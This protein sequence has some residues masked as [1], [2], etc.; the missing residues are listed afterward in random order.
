MK[1]KVADAG[2]RLLVLVLLVLTATQ[3]VYAAEYSIELSTSG[4]VVLGGTVEFHATLLTDGKPVDDQYEVDWSDNMNP[5]NT[6]KN[7]QSKHP[8]FNWTTTYSNNNH[9]GSY[10]TTVIVRRY[11]YITY[12]EAARKSIAFNLT[13]LLNGQM[14]L[15]QNDTAVESDY[16]SSAQTLNQTIVL[17]ESD[18]R[19]LDKAT[20]VRTYWFI[21][22]QYLGT[23]DEFSKLDNFTKENE[24]YT[25]EA[26]VVASF[27]KLPDQTQS[28]VFEARL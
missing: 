11:Y 27:D 24:E 26:L 7:L 8:Y 1:P 28:F 13:S 15:F 18:R 5:P 9:A 19:V 4:S 16:V 25:I 21:N 2:S 10:V 17:T 12:F 14:R 22:C 3:M 6:R 20:Y 23:S